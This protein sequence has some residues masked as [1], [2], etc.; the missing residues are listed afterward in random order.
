MASKRL[1]RIVIRQGIPFYEERSIWQR[2][3]KYIRYICTRWTY[4]FDEEYQNSL[5]VLAII[6]QVWGGWAITYLVTS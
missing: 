1:G 4:E 6:A 5:K 2:I 3:V